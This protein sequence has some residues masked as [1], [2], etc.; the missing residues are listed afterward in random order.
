VYVTDY[1]LG[2]VEVFDSEGKQLF[3]WGAKGSDDG[4]FSAPVAIA[5][6]RVGAVYVSDQANNTVQKFSLP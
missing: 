3:V 5:L 6:D 2:R 1:V 4:H